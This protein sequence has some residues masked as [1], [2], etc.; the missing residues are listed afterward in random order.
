MRGEGRGGRGEGGGER[1]VCRIIV[2]SVCVCVFVLMTSQHCHIRTYSV[3]VCVGAL[4]SYS[5][6][7][8][9][10][11][12]PAAVSIVTNTHTHSY[13]PCSPVPSVAAP[14]AHTHCPSRPTFEPAPSP[15][16][17]PSSP[18]TAAG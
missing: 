10:E 15:P 9:T 16:A 12:V 6:S 1:V 11:A 7:K 3:C 4:E 14:F 17:P 2:F 8:Q 18:A 5:S 13:R